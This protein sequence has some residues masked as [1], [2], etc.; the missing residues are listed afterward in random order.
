M[1]DDGQEQVKVGKGHR[2]RA[3]YVLP[4]LF[5]TAG[6]FCGF[7]AIIHA[8]SGQF[9]SA[10]VA[11]LLASVFDALDGRVAR[12]LGATSEFGAEYDSLSDM[13]A[14][15]IAPA[16]LVYHWSLVPFGQPGWVAAFLFAVAG[17]L[18]LAR[19]NVYSGNQDK[20]Y[21]QGLPIPAA[22]G[23]IASLV[24]LYEDQGWD[25]SYFSIPMMLLIYLLAFLMVSSI[26]FR[27]FKDVDL[28]SQEKFG[29][30]A[31]VVGVLIVVAMIPQVALFAILL[32]YALSG[33]LAKI[34]SLRRRKLA[35]ASSTDV[36]PPSDSTGT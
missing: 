28:K 19:F 8:A 14:F 33:P 31:K 35:K 20:R 30:L 32:G 9:F 23:V 11:I 25:P 16:A 17:A 13:V 34:A 1:A 29:V 2:G 26:P 10:A 15:G 18:R 24:L 6:L 5:T 7:Y 36:P 3:V 4:N 27:S 21:F 22:A 12:M